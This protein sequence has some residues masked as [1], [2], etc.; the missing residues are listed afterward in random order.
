VPPHAKARQEG[1]ATS[2]PVAKPIPA[3]SQARARAA[4]KNFSLSKFGEAKLP[5]NH[6][7][8][9]SRTPAFRKLT[10]DTLNKTIAASAILRTTQT[11][12]NT[13]NLGVSVS[14]PPPRMTEI[15]ASY[16]AAAGTVDL[17]EFIGVLESSRKGSEFY[18]NGNPT[19]MGVSV[20]TKVQA[21]INSV[22]GGKS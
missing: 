12:A 15:F 16:N 14:V 13:N 6:V 4:F 20:Q 5:T 1:A 2:S 9:V 21:I 19:A 11:A 18:T 3:A 10:A 7:G 22:T 17:E 8:A